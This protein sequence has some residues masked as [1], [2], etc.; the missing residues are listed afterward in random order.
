[1][2]FIVFATLI[3][4][5]FL[6]SCGKSLT[7][8]PQLTIQSITTV[9]PVNGEFNATIKFEDKQGDVGG[10]TFASVIVPTNVLPPPSGIQL[11]SII[12]DTVPDFPNNSTGQILVTLPANSFEQQT[13]R[14]DT[15][16]MKF[17]VTDRAGN[18]S[19][20][21]TSQMIVALYQ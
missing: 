19:D 10:G 11:P 6:A 1:M 20:T 16:I 14:N 8:K 3:T 18:K 9:I 15:L 13:L 12:L 17:A 2:K 4:P 7:T 21:V 5:V